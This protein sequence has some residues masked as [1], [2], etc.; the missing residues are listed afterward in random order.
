MAEEAGWW[1]PRG[2]GG[3]SR[4]VV[5][6]APDDDQYHYTDGR[7]VERMRAGLKAVVIPSARADGRSRAFD[8]TRAS[9]VHVDPNAPDGG[10]VL[11]LAAVAKREVSQAMKESEF[12]HEVFYRL[13]ETPRHQ[14]PQES[15]VPPTAGPVPYAPPAV[16]LPSVPLPAPPQPAAAQPPVPYPYPYPSPYAPPPPPAADPGLQATLAALVSGISQMNQR[17]AAPPAP[18]PPAEPRGR[19]KKARLRA[20]DRVVDDEAEEPRR[21]AR[22]SRRDDDDGDEFDDNDLVPIGAR[23]DRPTALP[24]YVRERDRRGDD[25]AEAEEAP[26]RRRKNQRVRE[27]T[28]AEETPA[29]PLDAEIVGFDRLK[30]KFVEGPVAKKAKVQVFFDLAEMGTIGTFFHAVVEARECVALVYDSRYKEGQQYSPPDTGDKVFKIHVPDLKK[31][32]SVSSMG[33]TFNLGVFDFVVLVKHDA[34]A[35]DFNQSRED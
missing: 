29:V 17:F 15:A 22:R 32:F 11:D 1:E 8:P 24:P 20:A 18:P 30:I 4:A 35:L 9:V 16:T 7:Q 28:A 13:G 21:P 5:R 23:P 10:V 25:E 14:P 31:S 6:H 26:P 12:P 3:G 33:F 34:E 2:A 27:M 19:Q